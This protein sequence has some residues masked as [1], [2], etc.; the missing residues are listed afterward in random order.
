MRR[1]IRLSTSSSRFYDGILGSA[2]SERPSGEIVGYPD[3]PAADLP[4]RRALLQGCERG[5]EHLGSELLGNVSPAEPP[6]QI[7]KDPRI[8]D[9]KETGEVLSV[10][11]RAP[12]CHV[13]AADPIS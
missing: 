7:E 10:H 5:S 3:Q 9:I 1:S 8:L 13:V 12:F 11:S 4:R 6:Q 2:L